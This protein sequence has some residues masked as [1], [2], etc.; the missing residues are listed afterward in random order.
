V[1]YLD[2]EE[3]REDYNGTILREGFGIGAL[4]LCVQYVLPFSGRRFLLFM[5]GGGG[6]YA[7]T[8]THALADEVSKAEM[9]AIS[10]GILA[11]FGMEYFLSPAVS[12][13][14][15]IRYRDPQIQSRNAFGRP[16]VVSNGITYPLE[17]RPFDSRINVNG[18]VYSLG[19]SFHF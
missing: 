12:A 5:G 9:S 13:I 6:L 3:E 8:R 1:E 15:E 4:E 17:Q 2:S 7:G 10:A 16:S 14:A 19:L 18:N 11:V